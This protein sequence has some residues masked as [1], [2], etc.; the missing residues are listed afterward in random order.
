[1]TAEIA[2]QRKSL[3]YVTR[4][5]RID[6]V[7]LGKH[8]LLR[9]KLRGLF[10]LR[11]CTTCWDSIYTQQKNIAQVSASLTIELYLS[12]FHSGERFPITSSQ[13][14]WKLKLWP[15][16]LISAPPKKKEHK[17][18]KQLWACRKRNLCSF[19]L[20]DLDGLFASPMFGTENRSPHFSNGLS[21]SPWTFGSFPRT[22]SCDTLPMLPW[23]KNS[24]K[25]CGLVDPLKGDVHS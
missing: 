4:S 19:R 7:W 10:L 23:L 25:A 3:N 11:M 18:I 16:E 15:I 1:M 13:L 12:M 20:C 24:T 22:G 17:K 2:H 9:G 21:K 5:C 14:L 8:K 6:P